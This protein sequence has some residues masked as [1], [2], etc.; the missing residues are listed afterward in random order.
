M[1][2]SFVDLRLA[3]KVLVVHGGLSALV[4]FSPLLDL[5]FFSRLVSPSQWATLSC[6][7]ANNENQVSKPSCVVKW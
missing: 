2:K 5:R 7:Y 3:V 4:C 6:L 1:N